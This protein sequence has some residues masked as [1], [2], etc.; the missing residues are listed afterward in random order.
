MVPIHSKPSDGLKLYSVKASSSQKPGVIQQQPVIWPPITSLQLPPLC[1]LVCL[2]QYNCLLYV[3]LT[4][5]DVSAVGSYRLKFSLLGIIFSI[6]TC[7][8]TSIHF[9]YILTKCHLIRTFT[10][11]HRLYPLPCFPPLFVNNIYY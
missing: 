11:N 8:T 4:L 9:L 6:S 1:L 10:Q 2:S 5:Q 3:F 7:F